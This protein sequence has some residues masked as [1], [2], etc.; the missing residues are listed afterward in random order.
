MKNILFS[1]S[2]FI[3]LIGWS[4]TINTY[5]YNE[6]FESFTTCSTTAGAA[7]TLSN[8]WFNVTTDDIDWTCDA[9]GTPSY[10][11]GPTTDYNPGTSTGKY[12]YT[13]S[14]TY[15]T[16]FP[17]KRA[18]L[19]SPWFNFTSLTAPQATIWYHM[20]GSSMGT[21]EVDARIGM[22]GT[23]S[24]VVP[25]FTDNQ[26]VWQQ[27]TVNLF[28]Y[29]GSDSVQ[30]RIVG[31]TGTNFYSD[32]AIDDIT[33]EQAPSCPTPSSL[34]AFN[35]MPTS[36]DLD[37]TENGTA[38]QWDIEYGLTGFAPTGTPSIAGIVAKPYN[39]SGLTASSTYDYYVRADCGGSGTSSWSGPYT[40]STPCLDT[41][42]W[43]DNVEA[44]NA[45]TSLTTSNCWIATQSGA[46]SW[47]ISGTGTTPSTGTG[48][49]NAYS[50]T[51]FFFTEASYGSVGDVAE[52]YTPYLDLTTATNPVLKFYYHMFGAD[53][54]DLYI[55]IFNGSWTTLD[56]IKG[57]QQNA[58]SDPWLLKSINLNSFVGAQIQVRFRA[59]SAGTYQGDMAIDDISIIEAPAND[60]TA[61]GLNI[62]NG[63][64]GLGA[65]IL[66]ITFVN[67][68]FNPINT[69][70]MIPVGYTDGVTPVNE[71]LTIAGTVN[72]GDTFNYTFS[73][74]YNVTNSGTINFTGWGSYTGDPNNF[75]DTISVAF[76][77]KPLIT[78]F[79]Y[80]E[81]FENGRNGWT[82][83]N[84]NNGT[85]AFGTPN[86][87]VIIGASSGDS[88]FVNG[89]LT[90]LYIGND[91]SFVESPCFDFSNMCSPVIEMDVWYES[92]FS[93]DGAN[94]Q[95]STDGGQTWNLIGNFGDN[96]N[97]YTDNT[98]NGNPGGSQEGWTGRNGSGSN[99]WIT[100]KHN[101]PG[102]DSVANVRF[103]IYFGSDGSVFDDGF[104]FDNVS[105]Y[106]GGLNLPA[107]TAFCIGDSSLVDAQGFAG[108]T[109][110]WST[111]DTTQSIWVDT[112]GTYTVQLTSNGCV[113]N[114]TILVN[115][116]DTTIS[117]DLGGTTSSCGNPVVLSAPSYPNTSYLW[118]TGE[119]TE[120]ITVTT[121]GQY[122]LTMN[123]MCAS[124]SDTIDV[125]IY[126]L[127][128]VLLNSFNNDTLCEGHV[129]VNLP[130]A[131]P[132]GGVY[133]GNGIVGNQFNPTTA[134][135]GTHNI[136]YTY[137][138]T[139]N[140]SASDTST[141]VVVQCVGINELSTLNGIEVYPNPSNAILNIAVDDLTNNTTAVITDINGRIVI[142][143]ILNNNLTQVD[144]TSL[145]NGLYIL[146]VQNENGVN[147]T[148]VIKN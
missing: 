24:N 48:P 148:K 6:D 25:P 81:D 111:G 40:F 28:A 41:M 132:S 5:P 124:E 16:G 39:L 141:I 93:W 137:T 10:S 91:N 76:N 119:T 62:S 96:Y 125:S 49:L 61:I 15:G 51:K 42:P 131:Y 17:N 34:T 54:G 89:G 84:T 80:Y 71:T 72:Q 101:L 128:F 113:F 90:G 134:G 27:L 79:P 87:A 146:I 56:S 103:R 46:Y 115:S 19:E 100:A 18:E 68:G 110:L 102:L 31:I 47:D 64:C 38:T 104:A 58:Q 109:Y 144:I 136:I 138:D 147:Y 23:W 30:F 127:P 33:V 133:S 20:Y 13:E 3:S 35:I 14:S 74:P 8:G 45:T 69:G 120:S 29:A 117:L 9:G 12:L 106:D 116:L 114:D 118:S 73:T 99:G 57:Q 77:F 92:E 4:Q 66:D 122:F 123:N 82:E 86:K 142:S 140:C 112:T 52:L 67:N 59:V 94:L 2:I 121:S 108:D 36:A 83:D 1:I 135:A 139:N 37:W 43:I 85:W 126:P 55:D 78:V 97:W 143:T 130:A 105:I 107:S 75:D 63:G 98:I 129:P 22:N 95:Y 11:T 50:G 88:C 70:T 21:L 53:M 26:N 44:H 60:I 7:C 65:Q 32:M 145:E